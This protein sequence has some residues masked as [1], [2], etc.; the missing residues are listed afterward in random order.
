MLNLYMYGDPGPAAVARNEPA[1]R[2]WM[3]QRFPT[4]ATTGAGA[5]TA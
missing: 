2:G 1:W 4:P 3:E 5:T